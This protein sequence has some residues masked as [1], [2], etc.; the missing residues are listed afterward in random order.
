MSEFCFVS[1]YQEKGRVGSFVPLLKNFMN[2]VRY[3]GMKPKALENVQT[4]K[5]PDLFAQE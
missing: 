2:L 4:A 5:P 3:N 1:I